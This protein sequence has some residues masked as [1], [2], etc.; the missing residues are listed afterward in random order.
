MNV[1][2]SFLRY[3]DDCFII[4]DDKWDKDD[5]ANILNGLHPNLKFKVEQ[6]RS[7]IPFLD[8]NVFFFN[9]QITTD[10]YFTPTDAHQYLID[11]AQIK[12]QRLLEM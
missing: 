9:S 7:Q 10:V 1:P 8:I 4:R 5:F 11:N 6:N 12:E 2:L 3:L